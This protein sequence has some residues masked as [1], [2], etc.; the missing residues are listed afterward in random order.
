MSPSVSNHCNSQ[1]P[2][3]T[4]A[5]TFSVAE[6]INRNFASAQTLSGGSALKGTSPLCNS[7]GD[8]NLI[9]AM[10][11]KFNGTTGLGLEPEILVKKVRMRSNTC[12][13]EVVFIKINVYR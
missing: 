6:G 11:S 3:L 9:D 7:L 5:H 4:G 13:T 12:E 8:Q 10:S 2:V 1:S